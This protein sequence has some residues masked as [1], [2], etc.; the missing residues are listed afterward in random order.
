LI[1]YFDASALVKRYVDEPEGEEVLRLL[2]DAIPA[3]SRLSEVEIASA[4]IRRWREGDL[5]AAERDRALAALAADLTAMNVIELAP[6]ISALAIRLLL[7]HGLRASDAVQL[8]SS[9]YL[10]RKVGR[11]VELVAFDRRLVAA[12]AREGLTPASSPPP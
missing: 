7:R 5:S 8:A 12:A 9:A 10:Q 11:T 3:T 6:E 2:A 4:L 1:R